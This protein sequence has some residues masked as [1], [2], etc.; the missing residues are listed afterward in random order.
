MMVNFNSLVSILEF[1]QIAI[2]A[3]LKDFPAPD[4][5]PYRN[6]LIRSIDNNL[7]PGQ[8][9]KSELLNQLANESQLR[10]RQQN[11]DEMMKARGL[12]GY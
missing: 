11:F 4:P 6:T 3:R 10:A 9:I 8:L 12:N 7:Q 5:N 2:D 1:M